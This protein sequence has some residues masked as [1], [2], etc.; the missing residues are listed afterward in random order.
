VQ[1]CAGR[2]RGSL[3][4]VYNW[5]FLRHRTTVSRTG[6]AHRAAT[7]K[8]QACKKSYMSRVEK[9][10]RV[11]HQLT[12]TPTTCSHVHQQLGA[13]HNMLACRMKD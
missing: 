11:A 4:G 10:M 1:A 5:F 9:R 6:Y 8:R 13:L 7:A 3:A 12:V 2:S